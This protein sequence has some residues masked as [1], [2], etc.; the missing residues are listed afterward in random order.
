ML[1]WKWDY[2]TSSFVFD[3]WIDGF[4]TNMY[5]GFVF[6]YS[7]YYRISLTLFSM[8]TF[9]SYGTN[10]CFVEST[11][12]IIW[13][14]LHG[15]LYISVILGKRI[16]SFWTHGLNQLSKETSCPPVELESGCSYTDNITLCFS[17]Y[18][19]YCLLYSYVT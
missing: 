12:K 2:Y 16:G 4:T 3:I 10:G 6:S 15:E 5:L 19:M 9:A 1:T 7:S 17:I 8:S 13:S 14:R 11:R 18:S